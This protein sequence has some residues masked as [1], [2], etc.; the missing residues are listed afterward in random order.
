MSQ[1]FLCRVTISVG[2]LR[3]SGNMAKSANQVAEVSF[4]K[5]QLNI[6]GRM[7]LVRGTENLRVPLRKSTASA[8]AGP[9]PAL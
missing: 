5:G 3:K 4:V 9:R 8:K 2:Q 7:T 6:K 1:Q